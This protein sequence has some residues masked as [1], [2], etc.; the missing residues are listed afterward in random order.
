ML[1]GKGKWGVN[2]SCD[3]CQRP[4]C[5]PALCEEQKPRTAH[6]YMVSFYWSVTTLTTIGYGD[7]SPITTAERWLGE[8]F[9]RVHW[10]A[11]PEA[12]RARR[13]NNLG[14][15]AMAVGSFFFGMLVGS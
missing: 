3:W 7:I 11:V 13:V 10:V 15:F 2:L 8:S 4:A 9:P 6:A 14:I 12:V 1:D 5:N